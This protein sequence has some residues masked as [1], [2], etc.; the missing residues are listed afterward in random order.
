[1]TTRIPSLTPIPFCSLGG[2]R[3]FSS[4]WW[5]D[6]L[7]YVTGIQISILHLYYDVRPRIRWRVPGWCG[8][9]YT[10]WHR[11]RYGWAPRDTWSLDVHLNRVLAGTLEHL[12]DH[13]LSYPATYTSHEQWESDLRRWAQ[14]FRED[15]QDVDIY[16]R[17]DNYTQ[18]RAEEDRRR[19]NLHAALKELEPLWEGL[20][21]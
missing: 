7:W 16:D 13:T 5:A 11:A 14:A 3:L 15:P 17:D 18:H 1:M 12:A 8:D 19:A 9:L 6:L 21:D 4:Y 10:Y 2:F 20:W